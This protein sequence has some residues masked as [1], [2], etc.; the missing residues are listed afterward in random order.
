MLIAEDSPLRRL[1]LPLRPDQTMFLDGMRVSIQ[2]ADVS[3]ARLLDTLARLARIHDTKNVDELGPTDTAICMLDAWSIIDSCHRLRELLQGLP[4]MKANDAGRQIFLRATSDV[5]KLRHVVQHLRNEIKDLVPL[6]LPVWGSLAWF[7]VDDEKM[8]A[9]KSC[10]VVTGNMSVRGEHPA[11]N[12]AGQ[13]I[14]GPV[15]HVTLTAGGVQISLSKVMQAIAQFTA[16]FERQFRAWLD[17]QPAGMP[18]A[19]GDLL[20]MAKFVGTPPEAAPVEPPD[21]VPPPADPSS[22]NG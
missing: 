6:G 11:V 2:M 21:T 8:F 20:L 1:P 7:V 15:D 10:V 4:G 3:Y 17:T 13:V 18:R 12:P 16:R 5:E 9:G 19:P 14:R 22:A